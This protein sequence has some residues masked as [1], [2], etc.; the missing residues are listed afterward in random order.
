MVNKTM[1]SGIVLVGLSG[2]VISTLALKRK[3]SGNKAMMKISGLKA[4]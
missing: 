2:V 4:E 3:V 1:S